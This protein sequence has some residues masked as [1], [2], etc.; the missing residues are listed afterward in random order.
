M[1]DQS[2]LS[3]VA[4]CLLF[5]VLFVG[6]PMW[7]LRRSQ[8]PSAGQPAP[9]EQFVWCWE[10][11]EWEDLP[12]PPTPGDDIRRKLAE[13]PGRGTP[14]LVPGEFAAALADETAKRAHLGLTG[15]LP[16]WASF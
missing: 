6:L 1:P 9:A 13:E 14:T 7:W 10:L 5:A 3:V 4:T 8:R 12:W 16:R 2:M 15:Q 11:D